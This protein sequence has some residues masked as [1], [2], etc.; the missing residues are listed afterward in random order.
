M[1]QQNFDV[2]II[3]GSYAGLS[4]G[5]ALGRSLKQVLI[6]DS[7]KPCNW[8]TPHSHNFLTQDGQTPAYIAAIAKQQVKKY[9]T[10]QFF[11]GLAVT[12]TKKQNGFEI[13][14]ASGERYFADKLVFATG[15]RDLLPDIDGAA[16]CWGISLLH[17]P[18]CH[19]YEVRNKK[20][21]ILGNGINGYEMAS[22]IANWTDDLTLYTNGPSM[23]TNEQTEK[24]AQHNIYIEERVI[25]SLQHIDGYINYI[26]FN[27]GE[28]SAITAMYSRNPFQQHCKIPQTLGC[29]LTEDGYIKVDQLQETNIKG[30]FAC[31]DNA[32]PMRTVAS[33]VAAGTSAGI[34]L[35]RQLINEN[36]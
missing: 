36:F 12:G 1:T 32:T 25:D 31:G 21:G 11:N 16:E 26:L 13:E 24:L 19:G 7:G 34:A 33:A 14:V 15:I 4:A 17:C 6:I 35:T 3:G 18:F 30:V 2:I 23:L 28:K 20:T 9:D 22:L 5:M 27:D 10:V 8:Q 29:I